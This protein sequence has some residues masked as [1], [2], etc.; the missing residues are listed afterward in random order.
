MAILSAVLFL[1]EDWNFRY[2]VAPTVLFAFGTGTFWGA[3]AAKQ[4][5]W[6]WF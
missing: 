3:L 5:R 1:R 4:A 2:F 6:T